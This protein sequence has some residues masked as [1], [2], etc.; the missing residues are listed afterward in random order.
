MTT[1]DRLPRLAA[2]WLQAAAAGRTPTAAE[3]CR[4]CP[5]MIPQLEDEIRRLT[6]ATVPPPDSGTFV[7][8]NPHPPSAAGFPSEIADYRLGQILGEGGMGRVYEAED[9][10]LGRKVALKVMR[11]DAAG[12][13]DA[14]ERFL[15]EARAAAAIEHDHVVT[16]HRVGEEHG[17]P[18]LVMPLLRGEPLDARLKREGRLP[19]RDALRIG[20]EIAEG[21]AAAH[22][23]GL[24]HR[25]IKPANVWLEGE[26]GRAKIL[27]FGL[28]RS[29]GAD[30]ELT[31]NG[32]IMG[33]PAYM[34]PEQARGEPV[35][36]RAD[37]FGLGCVLY[38]MV[39][40]KRPFDGDSAFAI[41]TAVTT[42]TPK[43]LTEWAG[44]P[45]RTSDFVASLLAKRPADRP[46][47][48]RAVAADLL[49]AEDD[50][51]A[52]TT[53][54]VELL[55]PG[56]TGVGGRKRR[57]RT[58]VLAAVGIVA[59]GAAAWAVA[60]FSGPD[61]KRAAV[62]DAKPVAP[63]AVPGEKSAGL[64]PLDSEWLKK[65]RA[66]T[67]A[68]RE[69]EVAEEMKRRNPGFD[70]K[71]TVQG[72][73]EDGDVKILKIDTS[74]VAD[75]NPIRAFSRLV[76]LT[77]G[78]SPGLVADLLPVAGMDG[79]SYLEV[80]DNRVSNLSPLEGTAIVHLCLDSNPVID[81]TPLAG[82]NL[83]HLQLD[84]TWATDL[85]PLKDAPLKTIDFR[86]SRATDPECLRGIPTLKTINGQ[87]AAEFW[88]E[89]DARA[90]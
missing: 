50:Q 19:L 79:L 6:A 16:V 74:W 10:A 17:I 58:A 22:D 31:R 9:V 59:A 60:K 27:D 89:W 24:I 77:A 5:E 84:S 46:A 63:V 29:R 26:R 30:K 33:T 41:M 37:L 42:E 81:L 65:V 76:W 85:A 2:A 34:A 47:S 90:R 14:R 20:R 52:G 83:Y 69:R 21:L 86:K 25:D 3:L 7:Q 75:L 36:F 55:P 62:A 23:A 15:R 40:G 12:D 38:Q 64:P 61:A 53:E 28:A 57:R 54:R 80:A 72:R 8:I 18:F 73:W 39:S 11:P 66:M 88:Q 49:R 32:A 1:S 4:D 70:G 43:S 67:P 56:S 71:L 45:R 44:V 35:D 82:M 78:G 51:A 68:G 48:A 87:P 13:P